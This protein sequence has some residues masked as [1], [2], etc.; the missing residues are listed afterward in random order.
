MPS[1]AAYAWRVW[2]SSNNRHT[3]QS[4]NA[5]DSLVSTIITL[6]SRVCCGVLDHWQMEYWF[7]SSS[8]W[9]QENPIA[10]HLWPFVRRIQRWPVEF[11]SKIPTMCVCDGVCVCECVCR[12]GDWHGDL[13]YYITCAVFIW[14]MIT[15]LNILH[16]WLWLQL[17]SHDVGIYLTPTINPFQ[18]N[19]PEIW[20]RDWNMSR[21]PM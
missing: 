20:N 2:L 7:N 3:Q 5:K 14:S 1:K 6:A 11:L 18:F 16:W 10:S 12:G 17:Y 4:G 8:G 15:R 19:S 9:K 21:L 13:L